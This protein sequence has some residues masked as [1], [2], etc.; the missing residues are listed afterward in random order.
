[1]D[2]AFLKTLAAVAETGSLAGAAG[3]LHLSPAAVHKQM[4]QLEYRLGVPLYQKV[5]RGIR[6]SA[7]GA[8]FLPYAQSA[9]AQVEAGRQA[10]EEWRGLRTG[11]VRVGTGPTLGS[12]WLPGLLKVFRTRFPGIMVTVATGSSD[13]LLANARLGRLDLA[14]LVASS[15]DSEPGFEVF[16][17]WE[18][19]LV[20]VA[21]DPA[22]PVRSTLSRLSRHPFIGF[23][24]DS[25]IDHAIE[26]FFA[27]FGLQPNTIMRF[28]NADAIRAILRSGLG[29][30]LLPV[31]TL[32]EDVAAGHLRLLHPRV[33][34]PTLKVELVRYAQTPL[35]P[36][37][38]A[39]VELARR[40]PLEQETSD[41]A[42]TETTK[43]GISKRPGPDTD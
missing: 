35:S 31:W 25:R 5:G 11:L 15:G 26:R 38:L 28:D 23:R 20:F 21:G 19:R 27:R 37:A 6:L 4:K 34:S 13:E 33:S 39:F 30:S 43:S 22:L 41:V 1:M 12:H 42:L 2:L 17:Q 18:S 24:K 14:L 29:Y 9:L 8:I 7:A 16:H 10:V 3:R 36:A 40:Q 32:R